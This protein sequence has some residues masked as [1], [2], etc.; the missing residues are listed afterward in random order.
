MEQHNVTDMLEALT[1]Q[2]L[3]H[4]PDDPRI[5]C[6]NF[7]ANMKKQGAKHLLTKADAETM[8]QMFDITNQ[9]SLTKQQAFRAIKTVLGPEHAVVKARAED[10]AATDRLNKQHFVRL[11]D[12]RSE[13][14]PTLSS[15]MPG[16]WQRVWMPHR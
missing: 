4:K 15:N 11:R 9:G 6:I 7:L 10:C 8:F 5:L 13:A 2:L 14:R 12:G 1:A 16:S 3:F